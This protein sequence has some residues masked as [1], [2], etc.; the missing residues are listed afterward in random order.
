MTGGVTGGVKMRSGI[1]DMMEMGTARM[2]EAVKFKLTNDRVMER[3]S[4]LRENEVYRYD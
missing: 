3:Q 2:L 4:N 1:W